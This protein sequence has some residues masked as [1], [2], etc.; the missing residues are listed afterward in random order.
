MLQQF[1]LI[2]L[3]Q[4]KT[5]SFSGIQQEFNFVYSTWVKLE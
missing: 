5:N 2:Y 4:I 1:I 3:K